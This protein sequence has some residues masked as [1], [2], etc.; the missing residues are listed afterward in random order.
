MPNLCIFLL[1]GGSNK[2]LLLL[3]IPPCPGVNK[4]QYGI[5]L[6]LIAAEGSLL[7]PVY[8]EPVS[9]FHPALV[10][11]SVPTAEARSPWSTGQ[12]RRLT[13]LIAV[14]LSIMWFGLY[15]WICF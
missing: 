10:N 1:L 15:Y 7:L 4:L 9:L 14:L 8:P 6:I 13:V 12:A 2:L 5:V 11:R 3:F